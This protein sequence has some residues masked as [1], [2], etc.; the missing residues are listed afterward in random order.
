MTQ[1]LNPV[2]RTPK[3]VWPT[4]GTV[5]D[6][7]TLAMAA[8]VAASWQVGPSGQVSDCP[9]VTR[10]KPPKHLAPTDFEH[11]MHLELH[12]QQITCSDVANTLETVPFELFSSLNKFTFNLWKSGLDQE[13]EGF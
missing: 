1:M 11:F 2:G 10:P 3:C 13:A 8:G 7:I 4:P 5:P 6:T 9:L 12:L